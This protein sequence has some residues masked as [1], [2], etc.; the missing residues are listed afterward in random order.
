[1]P[2]MGLHFV[3]MPCIKDAEREERDGFTTAV[4]AGTGFML[5]RRNCLE[6][7]VAGY[8][9]TKY[10]VAQVYPLPKV[11]S[12]NQYAL[13]DCIIEPETHIY[14]SEDFSF[15]R[16]WRDLG[17]KIW[18]DTRTR[19]GHIGTYRFEGTPDLSVLSLKGSQK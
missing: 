19:L 1:M 16:R 12:K 8:P 14:L 13:F 18:I 11:R 7:M 9:E 3:G 10:D 2:E 17:G 15:C 4:Y 6:R 5:I